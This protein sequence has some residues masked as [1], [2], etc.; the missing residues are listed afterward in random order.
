MKNKTL[1]TK[2]DDT[3]VAPSI[4]L[5]VATPCYGGMLTTN[6]FESC[7]GLMAECIQKRIGLHF[8]TI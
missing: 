8:D 6:Y 7:M 3:T 4:R 1:K 5:F 2:S